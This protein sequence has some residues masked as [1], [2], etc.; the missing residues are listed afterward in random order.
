MAESNWPLQNCALF[1][2]LSD[3]EIERL[4]SVSKFRQVKR[5]EPAY[6]PADFADGVFV[7]ISGRV[8]ICQITA[9]GKQSIMSFI[10]PGELFGEFAVIANE[11]RNE[12]AEAVLNSQ[13]ALVPKQEMLALM[14]RHPA[15]SIG[16]SK[17]IGF[18]RQRI[19][20][21]LRNLLFQSNRKRLIHLLIELVER[22]GQPVDGGIRLDIKLTHLEMANVI[23]STRE[24]VTVVLGHL[25]A[26]ELIQVSRR[27]ITVTNLEKL[28]SEV[29]E[30]KKAV[31]L[32]LSEPNEC[33]V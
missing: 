7:L 6:L 32:A 9:D 27:Q 21:R 12:Y 26:E 33:S 23:G 2:H 4:E 1:E 24:T 19:E 28:A 31:S 16:I 20:R 8:K 17:I 22:Y 18:R 15:I 14:E 13:V 10:E 25:Q 3:V 5:G 11:V 29:D 30:R